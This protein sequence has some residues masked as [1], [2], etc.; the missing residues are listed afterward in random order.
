MPH[1]HMRDGKWTGR[2]FGQVKHKGRKH[3]SSLV[4]T[5]GEAVQWEVDKRREL[6]SPPAPPP[7]AA[8]TATV[9]LLE[10]GNTYLDFAVRYVPKTYSEKKMILARLMS[11]PGLDVLTPAATFTAGQ[12]LDH[13]QEQFNERG[14]NA[15]NKERKNLAAAWAWGAKFKK[16]PKDNPFMEVPPFPERR[17]A[18]HVPNEE[19]FWRVVDAAQGQARTML[20]TFLHAAARRG[21]LFRLEWKDVDFEDGSLRLYTRKRKD[22]SMQED[23]IPMTGE[24]AW[25]LAEHQDR[26]GRPVEGLV[27]SH[28]EGR[29]KGEAFKEDR[30]FMHELCAFAE[31]RFFDRHAIRHL[32]ASILAKRGVPSVVIQGVLR[33]QRL[34]TT[35]KYVK[36]LDHL[37]P[38][39]R[40]LEGGRRQKAQH[41]AQQKAVTA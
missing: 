12:A 1:K 14:G 25:E 22:G 37:R 5:K 18:R 3:R 17:V 21:E 10:W 15:A 34:S 8:S 20:L 16:L 31:V 7:S 27:F 28:Q 33:H 19:E 26:L 35:E 30:K 40:L 23:W 2:W 39:L 24:L 32:T 13:L 6:E 29:H 38:H 41:R 36:R 11:R 4:P 9:S